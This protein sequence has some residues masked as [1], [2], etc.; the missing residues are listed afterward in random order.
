MRAVVFVVFLLDIG[1]Q[2]LYGNAAEADR[3]IKII[4][5]VE[6]LARR[7]IMDEFFVIFI[8]KADK[9][10]AELTLDF[11]LALGNVF[12][13]LLVFE[14][15]IPLA[16]DRRALHAVLRDR[17]RSM[18]LRTNMQHRDIFEAIHRVAVE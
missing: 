15:T 4:R 14:V 8:G 12:V 10:A 13:T 11:G 7:K 3:G 18:G 1:H 17:A 5:I 6:P 16:V 2:P 9:V